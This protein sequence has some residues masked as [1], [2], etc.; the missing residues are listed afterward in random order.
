MYPIVDNGQMLSNTLAKANLLCRN[1]QAVGES[2]D[3]R[4]SADLHRII[5][6]SW[7]GTG[8]YNCPFSRDELCRAMRRMQMTTPSRDEIHNSFL[9]ALS[10]EHIDSILA[11]YNQSC[12]LGIFPNSWKEGIILPI[13]KP[14][15]DPTL[16]TSYRPI[17]LL[18]CLGKL[19]ERLVAAR[20]E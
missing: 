13:L 19:L 20:L 2:G 16:S 4:A 17:T 15:K 3:L 7:A 9:K 8:D 5:V 14:G 12:Q 1:F 11:L 6:G 18:S 10:D